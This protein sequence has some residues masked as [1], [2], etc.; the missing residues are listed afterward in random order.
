M[1]RELAV[2]ATSSMVGMALFATYNSD[3][4]AT[5]LRELLDAEIKKWPL[6]KLTAAIIAQTRTKVY[7]DGGEGGVRDF[8]RR[9][10]RYVRCGA[11]RRIS[12]SAASFL[13]LGCWQ[14]V[15]LGMLA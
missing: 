12:V 13:R 10:C 1:H 3:V 8:G 4:V 6:N 14:R 5:V 15:S 7:E 2:C 11:S 9:R